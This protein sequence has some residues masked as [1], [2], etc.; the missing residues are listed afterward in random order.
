MM[1][2]KYI[3][4]DEAK[5]NA[6]GII[7]SAIVGFFLISLYHYGMAKYNEH[8]EA[9]AV[10]M[11]E[12]LAYVAQQ[13]DL[14]NRAAA[15]LRELDGAAQ[16]FA[17]G[18]YDMF[19]SNPKP[20]PRGLAVTPKRVAPHVATVLEMEEGLA[21]ISIRDYFSPDEIKEMGCERKGTVRYNGVCTPEY[22]F[23][24]AMESRTTRARNSR[25]ERYKNPAYGA[26]E[27]TEADSDEMY[28]RELELD[29]GCKFDN[30]TRYHGV[31]I[32]HEKMEAIEL[33]IRKD[34]RNSN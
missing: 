3:T 14:A 27:V 34:N 9:E 4:L 10:E 31:C 11:V 15:D 18:N 7:F 25:K 30:E 24:R 17:D 29:N 33:A 16:A 1:K 28:A 26:T 22:E 23:L 20:K 6:P 19:T 12:A 13:T 32:T 8:V 2:N 21:P 5:K